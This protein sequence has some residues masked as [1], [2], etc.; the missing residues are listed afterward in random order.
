MMRKEI[1][2]PFDELKTVSLECGECNAIVL[3]DITGPHDVTNCPAC[4][5]AFEPAIKNAL[6]RLHTL[7]AQMSE[8]STKFAFR[9]PVKD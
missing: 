5:R 7:H 9:I 8:L 2:I 3:F 4:N 6:G 1:V